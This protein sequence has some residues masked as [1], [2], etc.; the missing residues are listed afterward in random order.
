MLAV[1]DLRQTMD[2]Y[3]MKLGFKCGDTFGDPPVWC[4]L[5]RDGWAIMF[6]APPADDVRRDVPRRSRDYQIYYFNSDD[7]VALHEEFI[8][9]GAPVS[10]LRVTAY[11]MKEFDVRDPDDIW[12]WFGQPTDEAPTVQE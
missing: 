12:L 11:G 4:D 10:D 2:F 7:V 6:N 3:R 9:R 1:T 5:S 8:A